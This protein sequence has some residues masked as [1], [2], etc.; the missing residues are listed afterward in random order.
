MYLPS[1][2]RNTPKISDNTPNPKEITANI[3]MALP[4][5]IESHPEDTPRYTHTNAADVIARQ[6]PE[7]L[8][9]FLTF[10]E[11]AKPLLVAILTS[12]KSIAHSLLKVD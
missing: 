1:T 10:L 8:R 5:S 7:K 4:N 9:V 6:V 12:C 2:G 11:L 3:E